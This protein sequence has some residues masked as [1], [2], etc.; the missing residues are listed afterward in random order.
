MLVS[1][2]HGNP[3]T[4]S[5]P[6]PATLLDDA[7]TAYLGFR[8]DTGDRLK[9]V[10]VADPDLVLAHCLRG[11]FMMLFGQ[12]AMVPRAQRSLE[13]AR[14]AAQTIGVTPREA[15][16]M[17]ALA[18]WVAGDFAGATGRWE[19]IAAEHPRDVLAL[20]LA[21]YGCFY[22]GESKR[23]RDVL[24]LAL[25]AWDAAMPGYGFVL[26]CHAFGLEETG[27]YAA[28]ERTGREA[29]ERNPADIWAA[30]AVAH[31]FEMSGRPQEGAGWIVHLEGHWR[32]CNNFAYHALWHRCLFLLE[33]GALVSRARS[34]R[35]RGAAGVN[36]RPARHF[37]CGIAAVAA[38][39]GWG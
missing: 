17:A 14:A 3:V 35:S 10:F 37:E 4:T 25:P 28:A 33:L 29:V 1:D 16:H 23:M 5:G 6:G 39:T 36:R 19:A 34:L 24:A 26:G 11:Y 2:A 27:D 18:A 30:H 20:K 21:Q 32:E 31:V 38:R 8:K 9:A 13:A 12:R 15:A 22:S 7:V